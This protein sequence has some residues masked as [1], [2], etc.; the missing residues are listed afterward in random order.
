V[1]PPQ[2]PVAVPPQLL[3]PQPVQAAPL[4]PPQGV[5]PPLTKIVIT[6]LPPQCT[7][8]VQKHRLLDIPEEDES[9]GSQCQKFEDQDVPAINVS[10]GGGSPQ[11]EVQLGQ[12]G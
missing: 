9:T 4:Q 10:P 1:L 11:V 8:K 12:G 7:P 2:Q 6:P 5:Q 3:A